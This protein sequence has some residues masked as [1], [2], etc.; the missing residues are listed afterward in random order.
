MIALIGASASGKTEIAKILASKYGISKV[1][2]TTTR[3]MRIGEVDGRD[4]FFVSQ[5]E[6][7]KRINDGRFVEYINYNNNF[8]GSQKD[9]IADDKCLVVEPH[10]LN[11]Y[12]LLKDNHIV[13]FH[14][15]ASEKT[16]FNRMLLRGDSKENA[17][18]RIIKDRIEFADEKIGKCDYTIDTENLSINDIAD[19]IYSHYKKHLG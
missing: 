15:L 1:V 10:G 13:I 3:P 8:Y 18:S 2:T 17:E 11:K 7:N 12:R 14:L 5:E 4:Y 19:Y 9:Q 6:F 16:R